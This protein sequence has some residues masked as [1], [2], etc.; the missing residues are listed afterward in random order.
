MKKMFLIAA[1]SGLIAFSCGKKEDKVATDAPETEAA[2]PAQD[3]LSDT[4]RYEGKVVMATNQQWYVIKDGLRWR[5]NSVPASA[6]YLKTLPESPDNVIKN[7]PIETLQQF[8]EAGEIFPNL[9]FKKDEK[10]TTP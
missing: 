3:T 10:K 6:D 7:V 4:D 8:P 5:T 1:V 2:A 9:V